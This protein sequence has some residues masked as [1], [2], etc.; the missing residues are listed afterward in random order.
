MASVGWMAGSLEVMTCS[1]LVATLSSGMP[2][3]SIH[4]TIDEN[5]SRRRT[6]RH[7][8]ASRYDQVRS[9]ERGLRGERTAGSDVVAAS[10][11]GSGGSKTD[12]KNCRPLAGRGR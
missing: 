2:A 11:T 1:R 8:A 4:H 10:M 12:E 6:E 9:R 7:K 3:R 5:P